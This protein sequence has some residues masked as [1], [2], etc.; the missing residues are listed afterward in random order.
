VSIASDEQTNTILIS[1]TAD[2]LAVARKI[3]DTIDVGSKPIGPTGGDAMMQQYTVPAGSAEAMVTMLSDQFRTSRFRAVGN[4]LVLA[5]AYPNDQMEIAALI[6]GSAAT[7]TNSVAEFLPLSVAEAK[8]VALTLKGIY[9]TT[10]A[11]SGTTGPFIKEDATRNGILV[12]GTAEQ[13]ADIKN[14]LKTIDSGIAGSGGT[15]T[16][17]IMSLDRGSAAT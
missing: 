10:D 8:A 9:Q 12:R 4:N 17:R 15:G 1:C 11:R 2:R 7:P 5:L 3:L 6:K 13:V 14:V 16:M